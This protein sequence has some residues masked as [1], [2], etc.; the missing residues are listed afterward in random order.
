MMAFE[1]VV[2]RRLLLSLILFSETMEAVVPFCYF[3]SPWLFVAT[4]AGSEE[5]RETRLPRAEK[6]D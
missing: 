3:W 6:R 5:P 4:L 1:M 2:A